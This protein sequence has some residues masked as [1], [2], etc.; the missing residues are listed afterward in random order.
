[1]LA[2]DPYWQIALVPQKTGLESKRLWQFGTL[3]RNDLETSQW[4]K[5][6]YCVDPRWDRQARH[7]WD[8]KHSGGHSGSYAV[9]E[10]KIWD[11]LMQLLK[12]QLERNRDQ[13]DPRGK[14]PKEKIWYVSILTS[15]GTCRHMVWGHCLI[16]V[17]EKPQN[18]SSSKNGP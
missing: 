13:V 16:Q 2:E 6:G 4:R 5:T 1:M 7:K 17:E 10:P 12:S 8:R 9:V 18:T 15:S 3:T 11:G 14:E